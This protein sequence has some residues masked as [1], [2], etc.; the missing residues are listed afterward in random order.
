MGKQELGNQRHSARLP[1]A[2]CPILRYLIGF[3]LSA[4]LLQMQA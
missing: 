3:G 4:V 1:L 2:H